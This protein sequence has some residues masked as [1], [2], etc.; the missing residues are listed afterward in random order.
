[1]PLS[2][3]SCPSKV[4]FISP[5]PLKSWV[6]SWRE[7]PLISSENFRLV[8][9]YHSLCWG[10][11]CREEET[12]GPEGGRGW[13]LHWGVLTP[14]KSSLYLFLF[15]SQYHN[16]LKRKK[17][18]SLSVGANLPPHVRSLLCQENE[19]LPG[20]TPYSFLL[21]TSNWF[22]TISHKLWCVLTS[23]T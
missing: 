20:F 7:C 17:K 4:W 18:L 19:P 6:L 14:A 2:H 12:S 5:Q 16:R 10:F 3:F 15:S 13:E 21:L 1:M 11:W 22:A 23:S 9:S 8:V